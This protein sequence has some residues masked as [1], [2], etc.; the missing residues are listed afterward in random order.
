MSM[1]KVVDQMSKF[2]ASPVSRFFGSCIVIVIAVLFTSFTT[3]KSATDQ[4][5]EFA[6]FQFK[7]AIREVLAEEVTPKLNE[8]AQAIARL[9]EMVDMQMQSIYDET[10]RQIEK[11]YEKYQKGERDFTKVN[12]DAIAKTWKA[13]PDERKTDA[14]CV[15]Y[16]TLMAYYPNL[17]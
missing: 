15:K 12:F 13:L 9:D 4:I 1:E 3:N 16:T 7:T 6:N 17:K 2:L 10:V 11:T 14:L 8:N 5:S